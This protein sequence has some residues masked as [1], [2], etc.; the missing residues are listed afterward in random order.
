MT[1]TADDFQ[2]RLAK[3]L[4]DYWERS[5]KIMTD[6][7]VNAL[8]YE[9]RIGIFG[10]SGVGKSTLC[11]TLFGENVRA[12]SAIKGCT[13]D[14]GEV[15][16]EINGKKLYL[17]DVP[18]VSESLKHDEEYFNLYKEL[19]PKLDLLIWVARADER[20]FSSDEVYIEKI[21]RPLLSANKTPFIVALSNADK[22]EPSY[23]SKWHYD[24]E[25]GGA[26]PCRVERRAIKKSRRKNQCGRRFF[27]DLQRKRDSF[28]LPWE[29]EH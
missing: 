27:S 24:P 5:I 21:I 23:K 22:I 2:S 19:L 16:L 18:G 1:N 14:V 10:K 7:A 15:T 29:L 12:T 25:T 4:G 17:V 3:M 13:R 6:A 11:N 9:P 26:H 28:F 8:S 20:A